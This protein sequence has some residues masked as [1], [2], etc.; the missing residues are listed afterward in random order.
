M[1]PQPAY[2]VEAVR[3]DSVNVTRAEVW[4]ATIPRHERKGLHPSFASQT[5]H[6]MTDCR[7]W[8]EANGTFLRFVYH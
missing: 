4:D 5:D 8:A 3:Y 2:T 1:T 6:P 7:R